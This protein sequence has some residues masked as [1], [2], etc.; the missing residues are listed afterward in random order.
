MLVILHGALG[1]AHQFNSLCEHYP[2]SRVVEFYGHG[3]QVA[4]PGQPSI[5]AFV[6]QLEAELV[7]IGRP[8]NVFGYSMGGYVAMMLAL[9]RPELFRAILT[10]GTKLAWSEDTAASEAMK[11]QP[12]VIRAKV[13]AYAEDLARRHGDDRWPRL[14]A[15]TAAV[16]ADL[17]SNPRLTTDSVRSMSVPTRLCVGDRDEM[18]SIDETLGLY[19]G[20]Q[21][22]ADGKRH[23]MAVL[24]GVRHPIEKAPV[25]VVR[26]HI[27]E[28]LAG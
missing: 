26:Q 20:L 27:D 13:P 24:P 3:A 19:R 6:D 10:L 14:L 7:A 2:H 17:G 8:C 9:R 28:W 5:D 11:L 4:L 23:Q 25:H 1:S 22:G 21:A 12:D 16:M 18:V 15:E